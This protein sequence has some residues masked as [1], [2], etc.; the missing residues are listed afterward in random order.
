M[1]IMVVMTFTGCAVMDTSL[2]D[3]ADTLPTGDIR[4]VTYG[5]FGINPNTLVN[6]PEIDHEQYNSTKVKQRFMTGHK[7][8][9]GLA[10][11]VEL[12]CSFQS[13]FGAMNLGIKL[14]L[15]DNGTTKLA[16][17]PG[18]FYLS[19]EGPSFSNEDNGTEIYGEQ[20]ASGLELPIMLTVKQNRAVSLN[21]GAKLGYLMLDYYRSEGSDSPQRSVCQG[22]LNTSYTTLSVGMIIRYR[23]LLISPEIGVTRIGTSDGS[24][25]SVP[26]VNLGIGLD[27]HDKGWAK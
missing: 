26:L 14:K 12:D 3:T 17:M 4:A 21:F 2:M 27:F 5:V 23:R 8:G 11:N 22:E 19:N 7:I 9:L 20:Y 24:D 15:M 25:E 16:V 13:M 6:T 10:Q 1:G 18:A